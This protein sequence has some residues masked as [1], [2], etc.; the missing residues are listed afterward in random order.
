MYLNL[1][2]TSIFGGFNYTP[3]M[4][5]MCPQ[6]SVLENIASVKGWYW[7]LEI[8]IE[9]I[10]FNL[11]CWRWIT[12]Q[13]I[14]TLVDI[15]KISLEWCEILDSIHHQTELQLHQ[16]SF[17]QPLRKWLM[18]SLPTGHESPMI[19]SVPFSQHRKF[20]CKDTFTAI[21]RTYV[22]RD[23]QWDFP[24]ITKSTLLEMLNVINN[25]PEY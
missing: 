10:I 8:T 19:G 7:D 14:N 13:H 9:Y 4:F 12:I 18:I 6:V 24:G 1:F 11:D 3:N 25:G 15:W 23:N 16:K 2:Y 17:G 20:Y 22:L 5:K 21:V